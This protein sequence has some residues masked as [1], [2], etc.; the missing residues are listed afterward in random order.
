MSR[1]LSMTEARKEVRAQYSKAFARTDT[2]MAKVQIIIPGAIEGVCSETVLGVGAGV[3]KAWNDAWNNLRRDPLDPVQ[4]RGSPT[5][6]LNSDEQF[7][8]RSDV[9]STKKPVD[10]GQK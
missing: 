8:K 5:W 9:L 7:W 6:S 10:K 2:S 3:A 4:E 1:E